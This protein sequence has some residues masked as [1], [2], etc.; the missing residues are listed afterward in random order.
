M[1]AGTPRVVVSL[2]LSISIGVSFALGCSEKEN[3]PC[4]EG[5]ND[6]G[7]CTGCVS[8]G[9]RSYEGDLAWIQQEDSYGN[10]YEACAIQCV[11]GTKKT[12]RTSL[13]GGE[14]NYYDS[15]GRWVGRSECLD[16]GAFCPDEYG[17]GWNCM[18]TGETF[19]CSP[20]CVDFASENSSC[21]AGPP[22]NG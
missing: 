1:I 5:L 13:D 10:E 4:V 15:T 18:T 9:H 3:E 6:A 19:S 16:Y 8:G 7:V 21:P 20:S 2:S 12:N 11:D 17:N 14:T 22:C